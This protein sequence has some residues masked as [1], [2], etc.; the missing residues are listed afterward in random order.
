MTP[1]KSTLWRMAMLLLAA[2]ALM[3]C[4]RKGAEP[5]EARPAAAPATAAPAGAGT[6]GTTP[7]VTADVLAEVISVDRSAASITVTAATGGQTASEPGK[8]TT[9]ARGTAGAIADRRTL[10]VAPSVAGEL[11]RFEPGER[12]MLRCEMETRPGLT[13]LLPDLNACRLVTAIAPPAP[14]AGRGE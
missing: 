14:G 9:T 4:A 2:A 3:A 12:V 1:L 11:A 10:P 7:P 8:E 6:Q 5:R 13:I